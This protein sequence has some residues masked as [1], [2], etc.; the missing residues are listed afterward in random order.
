MLTKDLIADSMF[1]LVCYCYFRWSRIW[2]LSQVPPWHK[3]PAFYVLD[4]ISKNVYNPYA[5]KFAEFVV[6]L[7]L[8]SYRAVD[9]QTK[10][11]MEEMLVTWR[12]GSPTGKEVFGVA[13]QVMLERSIW[14]GS[15]PSSSNASGMNNV[16]GTLLSIMVQVL[17][18]FVVSKESPAS[19][20]GDK[21]ASISGA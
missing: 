7:F 1:N 15:D 18:H 17:I 21:V 19:S 12:T 2:S 9:Q 16:S 4:A 10:A 8:D 5:S 6:T 20:V 11:K 3:L 13:S 14:G